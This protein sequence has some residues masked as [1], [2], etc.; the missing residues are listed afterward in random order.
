[1]RNLSQKVKKKK[2]KSTKKSENANILSKHKKIDNA[3]K[4][5][6]IN[7]ISKC[8]MV[9]FSD[10]SSKNVYEETTSLFNEREAELVSVFGTYSSRDEA[11]HLRRIWEEACTQSIDVERHQLENS[12]NEMFNTKVCETLES[13]LIFEN[14]IIL[15][16]E[17]KILVQFQDRSVSELVGRKK[18][19][20]NDLI[21]TKSRDWH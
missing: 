15:Q 21:Q 17:E 5:H 8:D 6:Y 16:F 3:I 1:M 2:T 9:F 13:T 19:E 7:E 14:D 10:F 12:I 11:S 20:M 18:Q 4:K